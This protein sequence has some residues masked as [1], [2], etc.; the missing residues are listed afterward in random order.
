MNVLAWDYNDYIWEETGKHWLTFKK[1]VSP[2][3]LNELKI[4]LEYK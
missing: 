3:F 4:V 2:E 1:M